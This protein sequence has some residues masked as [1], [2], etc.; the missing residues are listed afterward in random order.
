MRAEEYRYS[1]GIATANDPPAGKEKPAG[2]MRPGAGQAPARLVREALSLLSF[3]IGKPLLEKMLKAA[4]KNG[5]SVEE[6]LIASGNVT[7]AT[8]YEALARDLGLTFVPAPDGTRVQDI[9]G[10]D[11][12]L[13]C[14]NMIRITHPW[15]P[16][17]TAFVPQLDRIESLKEL[18]ERMPGL[19]RSLVVT[20]PTALRAAVWASGARRRVTETTQALFEHAPDFSARVVFYGK[21]GFYAGVIACA[22]LAA[23]MLWPVPFLTGLHILLALV[24]F[25]NFFI[26]FSALWLQHAAPLAAT[27]PPPDEPLPVYS[28][29]V[30]LYRE[31]PVVRQLVSALNGLDWP[32]SRLD[33]KLICEEDDAETLEALKEIPLGPWY[34][35]VPVPA[36]HPRTKPKAL[37]YALPGARGDYLAIYD[38]EDRP[39]P[40]Q[41]REAYERFRN[42][43]E[44]VVCLQAP[45]VISN[46]AA[47]WLSALFAVEYAG[48]F[49]GL[50]PLLAFQKLPIPL[51][52][53]S[54]HFRTKTLK[55][56][57]G[58]DP[59]NMTEDAD[60][61]MRFHRLGHRTEIISLPTL[62]DAPTRARSW[63]GQRSRWFKG[64][65][66]TWLVL[67]RQPRRLA[68]ETGLRS[69]AVLQVLIGGML[70]SSLLHPFIFMVLAYII[71]GML[72]G[73]L[74][75]DGTTAVFFFTIDI[76]NLFGS[77]AVF[78]ALGRKR[79]SESEQRDVGWRW[80]LVPF[81]WML[82]SAAAWR[83]L[84]ELKTN[85]FYWNKTAHKPAAVS[86]N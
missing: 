6:E 22:L 46:P 14:P 47:S 74:L 49:R 38:A 79:M 61:G 5:T 69:F 52:G 43:P 1:S 12:Q 58:W 42:A 73:H 53:T 8:Y 33:I 82:M 60:L 77:Y 51:G 62:E 26:R 20:T 25:A 36:R 19:K 64:W 17:V 21:Q 11:S 40:G 80:L 18:L 50:L 27:P 39:A 29:F 65:M 71:Y 55:E 81:Y 4:M 35:V 86:Q 66:Q 67:M 41:L 56:V 45:L 72:S 59:Y 70:L 37:T 32:H 31:G 48:L 75:L 68:V 9:A 24:F 83:A 44:K 76:L 54:N 30:A 28:V 57:G 2:E 16:T 3:G 84:I 85:P 7:E 78:V 10:I 23:G 15:E 63:I 13:L 34:E